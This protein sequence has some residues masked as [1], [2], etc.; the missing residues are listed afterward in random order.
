MVRA[1][2]ATHWREAKKRD[3]LDDLFL[4]LTGKAENPGVRESDRHLAT[5]GSA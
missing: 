5:L 1:M 3:T 4:Q 2:Q